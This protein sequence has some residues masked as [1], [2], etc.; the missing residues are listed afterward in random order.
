M[1]FFFKFNLYII[2]ILDL[3]FTNNEIFSIKDEGKF[4]I[5]IL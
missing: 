1:I 4:D 5:K 3:S 2:I